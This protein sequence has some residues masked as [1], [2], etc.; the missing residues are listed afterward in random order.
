LGATGNECRLSVVVSQKRRWAR[1][2]MPCRRIS[3][4]TRPRLTR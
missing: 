3:R 1:A 4:S 2:R